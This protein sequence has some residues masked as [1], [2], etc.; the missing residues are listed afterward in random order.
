MTFLGRMTNM[1]TALLLVAALW[2]PN[3]AGSTS[4]LRGRAGLHLAVGQ[5][6]ETAPG[7]T[8]T[9]ASVWPKEALAG[10]GT[11]VTKAGTAAGAAAPP[12]PKA[13]AAA[14]SEASQKPNASVGGAGMPEPVN[15]PPGGIK[16]AT[17]PAMLPPLAK[18][19]AANCTPMN[20]SAT[21]KQIQS[22]A[23]V[24][25]SAAQAA[26]ES[27]N[28]AGAEPSEMASTAYAMASEASLIWGQLIKTADRTE[29][30]L[31]SARNELRVQ[32]RI[33]QRAS[34][35]YEQAI[36]QIHDFPPDIPAMQSAQ[37]L[38][39]THRT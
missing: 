27:V 20:Q 6:S 11:P 32:K 19:P 4:Q 33:S 34:R 35:A 21:V 38:A 10:A 22:A 31:A 37:A 18:A 2:L 15:V 39:G 3:I 1:K 28:K 36:T 13:K 16:N 25:A 23:H 30:D 26:L 17:E 9:A 24:A 7:P 29:V 5:V 14:S 12:A 8:T